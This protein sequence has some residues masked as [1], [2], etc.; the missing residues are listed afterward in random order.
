MVRLAVEERPVTRWYRDE[1]YL[2]PYVRQKAALEALRA[3][4]PEPSAVVPTLV[5]ELRHARRGVREG[6]AD[7]IVFFGPQAKEAVP[8]LIAALS[9]DFPVHAVR[10]LG[11]IGPGAEAAIPALTK[12]AQDEKVDVLSI[13]AKLALKAIQGWAPGLPGS[14]KPD[15]K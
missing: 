10:A 3:L 8:A 2:S 1:S 13:H 5:A 9:E 12:I 6:A 11:A 15:P 7:F 14:D 4:K